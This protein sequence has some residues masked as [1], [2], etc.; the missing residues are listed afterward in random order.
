[1]G[2]VPLQ[3]R[4]IPEL[5]SARVCRAKTLGEQLSPTKHGLP[6]LRI[7]SQDPASHRTQWNPKSD[8][9]KADLA[10]LIAGVQTVASESHIRVV[11]KPWKGAL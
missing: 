3:W 8:L 4:N 1:M 9:P 5:H 2:R 11:M 6:I 7:N 10:V